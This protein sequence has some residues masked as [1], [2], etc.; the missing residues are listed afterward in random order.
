MPQIRVVAFDDHDLFR[1]GLV[2]LLQRENQIVV[3]GEADTS[4]DAVSIVSQSTADIVLLDVEIPGPPTYATVRALKRESPTTH[5]VIL[6]MHVDRV[7]E[8]ELL[9]AGAS[10]YLTKSL[11]SAALISTLRGLSPLA[12]TS[13]QPAPT[14][15]RLKDRRL[16]S[17]RE[18]Q[19]LRLLGR[20]RTNAEIAQ[21][22]SITVGTVKRH[23]SNLYAKLGATSRMDAVR[24]AARFGLAS[25]VDDSEDA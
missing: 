23:T 6:T 14:A 25:G 18:E 15:L 20:A 9:R 24:K 17:E 16:L 1:E 22:L 19:V 21:S 3:V 8:Y 7:L 5:V 4:W 10:A 11:P 2:S 12:S 13:Q